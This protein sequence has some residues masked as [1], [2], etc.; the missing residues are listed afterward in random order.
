[1][2]SAPMMWLSCN[3]GGEVVVAGVVEK[4]ST[5][6]TALECHELPTTQWRFSIAVVGFVFFFLLR[7]FL[8]VVV[9]VVVVLLSVLVPV[10]SVV[11]PSRPM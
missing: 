7:T 9:V 3:E 10:P 2:C 4:N 6:L 11:A 5:G 8:P 1:M